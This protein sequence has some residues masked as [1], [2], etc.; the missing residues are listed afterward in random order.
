MSRPISLLA[1]TV[2]GLSFDGAEPAEET[3][4]PADASD[5]AMPSGTW[6]RAELATQRE[7][8]CRGLGRPAGLD[9]A[10]PVVQGN[11]SAAG[12]STATVN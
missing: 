2:N 10:L 11:N 3:F 5:R 9:V 7:K 6:L 4:T 12:T 1:R 8:M